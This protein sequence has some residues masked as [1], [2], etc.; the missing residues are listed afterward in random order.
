MSTLN[1]IL[2]NLRFMGELNVSAREKIIRAF[3]AT[4]TEKTIPAATQIFQEGDLDSDKGYVLL[5]GDIRV[6][7]STGPEITVSAPEL[8]GEMVQF[9]P[10]AVRTATIEALGDVR[11]L[12][13]A[14]SRLDE[15]L[16]RI[17]SPED[18]EKIQKVL[19]GYAWAHFTQ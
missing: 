3:E 19:Q 11:V 18:S 12:S 4:G 8:I 10:T 16:I 2:L 9:N 5:Q 7:K 6:I 1:E 15:A 17:C 14:W 13:F